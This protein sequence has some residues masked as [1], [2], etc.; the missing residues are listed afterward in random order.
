MQVMFMHI[1]FLFSSSKLNEW[2]CVIFTNC[3]VILNN[4]VGVG[5]NS[6]YINYL[7][8]YL[9]NVIKYLINLLNKVQ[10]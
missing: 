2:I 10:I 4:V 1:I 8:N 3:S 5:N 9:V 6:P 7:V